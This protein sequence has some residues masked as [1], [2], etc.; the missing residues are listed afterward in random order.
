VTHSKSAYATGVLGEVVDGAPG[1]WSAAVRGINSGKGPLGVGVWG[2]HKGQ[3]W[4]L[5]ATS[6]AGIAAWFEGDIVVSHGN[7][8]G[9]VTAYAGL[10]DG[11]DPLEAGD[12]VMVSGVSAPLAGASRPLLR[13][14]RVT[15]SD[16][17]GLLAVVQ[18][19]GLLAGTQGGP[20][21]RVDSLIRAEGPAAPG[22]YL[23]VTFHGLVQVKVDA[24]HGAIH[25]GDMLTLASSPAG[26]AARA[27]ETSKGLRIGRA[28]EGLE[29]GKGLI[30]VMLGQQGGY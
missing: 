6:P 27:P 21:Q 19:R 28:M 20:D 26:Q 1:E 17:G 13:V 29:E 3:G 9:C 22:D 7:C 23:F 4:G 5:Y 25:P 2:E 16:A 12:L 10:N 8:H 14:H 18:S 15:A 30:W 24:D 11:Q